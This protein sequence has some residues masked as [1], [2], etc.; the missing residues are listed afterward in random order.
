MVI[1]FTN[2]SPPAS[3]EALEA[4]RRD[5]GLALPD[6]YLAFLREHNGG[7]VRPNVVAD[8]DDLAVRAFLSAGPT[9]NENLNSVQK[10]REAFSPGGWSDYDLPASMLPVA[11]DDL[12][13][14][15]LLSLSELDPGSV[16]FWDHEAPLDENP[17]RRV[18]DTFGAFVAGLQPD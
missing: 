9:P 10:M 8:H 4:L 17:F 14:Y 1:D 12:G 18:A 15:Y 7:Y 5:V 3:E 11:M 6:D 16:W 13:N 2:E